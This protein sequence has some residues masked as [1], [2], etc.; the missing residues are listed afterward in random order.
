MGF[1]GGFRWVAVLAASVAL[2]DATLL[3]ADT[4]S[5]TAGARSM[6]L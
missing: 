5:W 2:L 3:S 1:R 6:A 4:S